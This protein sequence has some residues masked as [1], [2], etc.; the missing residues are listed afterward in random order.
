MSVAK[1]DVQNIGGYGFAADAFRGS[2]CLSLRLLSIIDIIT[3]SSLE[4]IPS[5]AGLV[6]HG[7]IHTLV[8]RLATGIRFRIGTSRS[9]SAGHTTT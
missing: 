1:K 9:V 7:P 5:V 3:G 2:T 6:E 8:H 4:K